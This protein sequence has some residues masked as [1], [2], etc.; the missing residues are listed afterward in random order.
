MTVQELKQYPYLSKSIKMYQNELADLYS[1]S[2]EFTSPDLSGIPHCTSK[3]S[4]VEDGRLRNEERIKE[5]TGKIDEC[6]SLLKKYDEFFHSIENIELSL[7]FELRYKKQLSWVQISAKTGCKKSPEAI[8]QIC[9][10][11]LAEKIMECYICYDSM[12]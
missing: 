9:Y 4:K 1:D 6:Y 5:I 10:R 8:K 2:A 12:C 11:Y 7:Y 3:Y